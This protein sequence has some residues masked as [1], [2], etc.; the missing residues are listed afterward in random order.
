MQKCTQV[1][2]SLSAFAFKAL[3]DSVHSTI[4]I[5]PMK[6]P[7]NNPWTKPTT[8]KDERIATPCVDKRYFIACGCLESS[9]SSKIAIIAIKALIFRF[10]ALR[11]LI[12]SMMLHRRYKAGRSNVS[13]PEHE[14]RQIHHWLAL[15]IR[16]ATHQ[17]LG[18]KR[19]ANAPQIQLKTAV[20]A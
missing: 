19:F 15:A 5:W 11:P 20:V 9:W 10:N 4:Q 6:K 8:A 13:K 17:R 2:L 16:A 1:S 3:R 12:E 7:L 14:S 18:L